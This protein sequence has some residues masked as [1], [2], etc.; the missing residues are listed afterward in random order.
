M[1]VINNGAFFVLSSFNQNSPKVWLLARNSFLAAEPKT[2]K[3]MEWND[4]NSIPRI[5]RKINF[6]L[7]CNLKFCKLYNAWCHSIGSL[8]FS[9][10]INHPKRR[11]QTMRSFF[12]VRK[13]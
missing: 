6:A 12:G 13:L 8:P 4:K 7:D 11:V 9:G 10:H 5:Q 1:G 2:P 3:I